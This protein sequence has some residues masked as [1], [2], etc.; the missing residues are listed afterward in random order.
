MRAPERQRPPPVPKDGDRKDRQ[1]LIRALI[2]DLPRPLRTVLGILLV[3]S[4]CAFVI[5]SSWAVLAGHGGTFNF[6][7]LIS[8]SLPVWED[9]SVLKCRLF[10][11]SAKVQLEIIITGKQTQVSTLKSEYNA[12]VKQGGASY[13]AGEP[14]R[15]NEYY[16]DKIK[17]LE[18]DIAN[19]ERET[20]DALDKLDAEREK[21][22][23]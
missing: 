5:A 7:N 10:A 1:S 20:K 9:P 16:P 18:I 13:T 11:E 8:A 19:L 2:V 14:S 17:K 6:L 23:K 12:L 21:N 3:L 4:L 22:C 15:V